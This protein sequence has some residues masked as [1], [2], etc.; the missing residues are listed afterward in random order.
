MFPQQF[1]RGFIERQQK[2]RP[3]VQAEEFAVGKAQVA[4]VQAAA[5][6]RHVAFS[7]ENLKAGGRRRADQQIADHDQPLSG[8]S[9]D[10]DIDVH[11]SS[12]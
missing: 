6:S 2:V 5:D 12:R 4:P 7:G 3:F 10:S 9:G 1:Q 8:F 11:N